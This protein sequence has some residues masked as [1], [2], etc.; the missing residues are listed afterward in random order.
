MNKKEEN[1]K[2]LGAHIEDQLYNALMKLSYEEGKHVMTVAEEAFAAHVV[3]KADKSKNATVRIQA[4]VIEDKDRQNRL[5][6][7]KQLYVSHMTLQSEEGAEQL[8]FLCDLAGVT[9]E[10]L[11]DKMNESPHLSEVLKGKDS[12][13]AAELWLL[14]KLK[15]GASYAAKTIIEE[16]EK[17]GYK[18]HIIVDARAKIAATTSFEINSIKQGSA[19]FW[20]LSAKNQVIQ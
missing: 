20:K 6:Q 10:N 14:E 5:A 18:K 8:K 3:N 13:S 12:L 2:W 4:A 7:L 9:L 16:A 11:V 19:W 1:R 15:P 17:A